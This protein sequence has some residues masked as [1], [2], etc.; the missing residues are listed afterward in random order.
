MEDTIG[1]NCGTSVGD[2]ILRILGTVNPRISPLDAY[3]F[4]ML[5]GWGLIRGGAYSR[6]AY[7]RGGLIRGRAYSRGAYKIISQMSYK[8]LIVKAPFLRTTTRTV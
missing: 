7:S 8:K 2:V 5:F 3:L 6:G 4:L 1:R